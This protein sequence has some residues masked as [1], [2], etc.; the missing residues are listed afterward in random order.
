MQELINE[1]KLFEMHMPYPA[2]G[3]DALEGGV[4]IHKA[5]TLELEPPTVLSY[6]DIKTNNPFKL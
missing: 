4:S 6:S 2:D 3:L 1:G 5:K